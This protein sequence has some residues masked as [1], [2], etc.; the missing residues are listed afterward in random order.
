MLCFPTGSVRSRLRHKN[1]REAGASGL[2]IPKRSLGTSDLVWFRL[3]RL[4]IIDYAFAQAA[5][6]RFQLKPSNRHLTSHAGLALIGQCFEG[7]TEW[8]GRPLSHV[9][10]ALARLRRFG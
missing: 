3:C 2:R 10:K 8:T 5:K 4:R 7:A 9:A 6:P 1:K